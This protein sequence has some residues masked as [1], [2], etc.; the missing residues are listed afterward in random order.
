[1]SRAARS[2]SRTTDQKPLQIGDTV[3]LWRTTSDFK[4]WIGP[5]ILVAESNNQRSL[6]VS[7]RGYLVKA[8]REQVRRATS[9]E[10]LGADLVKVLSAELLENLES[11]RLKNFKDIEQEGGPIQN[12]DDMEVEPAAHASP[13]V[14]EAPLEPI[15]EEEGL[16]PSVED[17]GQDT[18]PEAEAPRPLPDQVPHVLSGL[19]EQ[20]TA[21][22]SSA[23]ATPRPSRRPSTMQVDEASG[24][25][26]PFGPS[27]HVSESSRPTPYPFVEA[28]PPL[29]RPP[30]ST[31]FME[32]MDDEDRVKW[33][34]NKTYN[35]WEPVVASKETFTLKESIAVFSGGERRFFITKKKVSPGEVIFRDLPEKFK[36]VFRKSRNKEIASLL[37]SG[38]IAILSV[39]ESREFLKKFPEYVLTSRYVDRWKPTGDQAVLPE[40]WNPEDYV[41]DGNNAAEPK[42]RWCVVGWRDPHIHEIERAAPT[43]L[44]S[45]L[46][47][48]CQL[49]ATRRWKGYAKDAKTA[50]LQAEPTTHRQ[51]LAC[52]M[53]SD[54]SFPGYESE[55]LILLLT[56]V[57]GLVS[58]PAWRRRS[59]LELLVK[60]LKYRVNPFD[61]CVL[62][63]DAD[64]DN[65]DEQVTV[66]GQIDLLPHPWHHRH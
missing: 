14:M 57:Y 33:W 34:R 17:R 54:E 46:Y 4:G 23:N 8:S 61:R 5:R 1:M 31:Y 28:P 7:V 51:R 42:S 22:P 39:K 2:N 60:E 12:L 21:A 56:E 48:F 38:A 30:A 47:L 63:L 49:S 35:R 6:W 11:G 18:A 50:F 41:M 16:E 62:T 53:P 29:P 32:A 36:K 3:Y 27:R 40:S 26:W 24:G 64:V 44:T 15:Q 37:N 65:P 19:D 52:R 45:S 66:Y 25:S 20:S 13:N 43:P 59:L 55:Q 58:G 10:S 9:E